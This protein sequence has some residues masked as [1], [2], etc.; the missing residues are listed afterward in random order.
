MRLINNLGAF[1]FSHFVLKKRKILSLS[2]TN[3]GKNP[4]FPE[5]PPSCS[6]NERQHRRAYDRALLCAASHSGRAP[7]ILPGL[8][9]VTQRTAG[10][11]RRSWQGIQGSHSVVNSRTGP[12]TS[13]SELH[14]AASAA[15]EPL[16]PPPTPT[17]SLTSGPQMLLL[18]HRRKRDQHIWATSTLSFS[19]QNFC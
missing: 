7:S 14:D 1:F 13:S 9:W 5:I 4:Q 17:P 3:E 12:R 10:G 18:F 16:T 11:W 6:K 15:P 2:L 19:L 8:P